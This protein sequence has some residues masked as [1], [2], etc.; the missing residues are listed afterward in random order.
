MAKHSETLEELVVYRKLYDDGGLWVR[1]KQMFL[2]SVTVDGKQAARGLSSWGPIR[3]VIEWGMTA[4]PNSSAEA[5]DRWPAPPTRRPWPPASRVFHG[6]SAGA[7]VVHGA[8][9]AQE[10]EAVR[11]RGPCARRR[12]YLRKHWYT[13]LVE[14]GE[15]ITLYA[16][17]QPAQ[18]PQEPLVPLHDEPGPNRSTAEHAENAEEEKKKEE[19]G[20][21]G[22][23]G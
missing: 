12:V 11:P 1:P 20:C 3:G 2:E 21:R 14:S 4:A 16:E 5:S 10:V 8:G 18:E 15:A 13:V 17:Q 6:S 22:C 7:K 23:R 9:R 19:Q